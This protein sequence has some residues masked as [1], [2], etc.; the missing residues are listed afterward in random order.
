METKEITNFG[1]RLTR[2]VN[3]D[4]NSGFANFTTSYGYN[5]FSKP[6]NLTWMRGPIDITSGTG[7]TGLVVAGKTRFETRDQYVYVVDDAAKLIK[8]KVYSRG[9]PPGGNTL[10]ASVLG[11]ASLGGDNFESGA[12]MEFFGQSERIY[13]GD[14]N[15]VRK[16]DFDGSGVASIVGSYYG[17]SGGGRPLKPFAGNL[18]FANGNTIGLISATGTVTSSVIGTGLGNL[19]S[20]LNPPLPIEYLVRDIDVTQDYNYI[21]IAASTTPPDVSLLT[22]GD[23]ASYGAIGDSA[24]FRWNGVDQTITSGQQ[25]PAGSISA[26]HS[27]LDKELFFSSDFLGGTVGDGVNKILSLPGNK[28]PLPNA[29]AVNGNF[30]TWLTPEVNSAGTGINAAMY[31]WGSLDNENP[32]GLYRMFRYTPTLSNGYMYQ[33]PFNI[34]PSGSY[35]NVYVNKTGVGVQAY[36]QHLISFYE[37]NSSTSSKKFLQFFIT[38]LN[39]TVTSGEGVYE[40]QI[41]LFSKKITTKQIRVYTEPTVTGNGFQIDLI[42][43]DGSVLSGGTGTYSYTAGTDVTLLQGALERIDFNLT[44]TTYALGIRISN[45]GTKNMVIKKIEI[46]WTEQGK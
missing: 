35:S 23:D 44:P 38:P 24:L 15:G 37:V 11:S 25:L 1:G 19:S 8:I 12:S 17:N 41:Q 18:V 26:L 3:G 43:S 45:T 31:Y 30:I 21:N 7:I 32:Q 34:I 39:D 42:G 13:I 28:P 36:G 46:D 4:L 9:S 22:A 40:T 2:I 27:Y 5:P 14:L 10:T 29:T 33:T 16:I 6:G 20:Q